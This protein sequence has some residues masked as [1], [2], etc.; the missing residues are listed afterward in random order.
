MPSKHSCTLSI[1][2]AMYNIQDYIRY[3]LDSCVSQIGV[4]D[5]DYE[6]IIV[7]DGSADNSLA[8]AQE[9]AASRDN[10]RIVSQDNA[11]LSAARNTG[12]ESARGEYIWF[13]DGD[14]A[15]A[16]D[17]VSIILANIS[18]DGAD[19]YMC[20]FSTFESEDLIDTSAFK[21]YKDLSGAEIHEKHLHI[22]PMMAW[23][24]I[25]RTDR[26]RENGLVFLPGIYHEDFEFSVKAHHCM[27]SISF[28]G[29]SLY[30]YR[31]AR[32]DSI[33]D[34]AGRDNTKSLVSVIAII[35]S[36]SS[37]FKSDD[38]R[39]VRMLFGVC[40]VLFFSK[41]YDSSCPVKE[42]T[43]SLYKANRRRLYGM[44]WHSGQLKKRVLMVLTVLLPR[45]VLCR[46]YAYVRGQSK[47]M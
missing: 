21:A 8:I 47:L 45:P 41:W 1:V 29:Q 15:I 30:H 34:I 28:I 20:N 7:N 24:T 22:L 38:S 32:K 43:A 9:Y 33:M 13:V 37:F 2:I 31:L 27:E 5:G 35:D 14:D 19:A 16:N 23:L 36:F 3:C 44:M 42:T 46:V 12:M 6:I 17:A 40:A 11:G 39:F 18:K 26:L 4:Q 25:Y 10:V